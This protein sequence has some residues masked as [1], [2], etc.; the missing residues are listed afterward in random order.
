MEF[1]KHHGNCVVPTKYQQNQQLAHWAKFL[2]HESHQLFTTGTS[3][4][5][6]EKAMELAEFGFYKK[7]NGFEGVQDMLYFYNKTF[8]KKSPVETEVILHYAS[9]EVVHP[10]EM[11]PFAVAGVIDPQEAE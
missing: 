5:K 6:I 11:E 4:V 2:R 8:K 7:K 1:V 10:Q 3:K 9:A